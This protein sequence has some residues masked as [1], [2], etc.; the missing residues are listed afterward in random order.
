MV[1]YLCY[2]QDLV[3]FL[4]QIFEILYSI[5]SFLTQCRMKSTVF[6]AERILSS[7]KF[8]KM[9]DHLRGQKGYKIG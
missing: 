5:C 4:K 9:H 3:D 8:C 1:S 6:G 2:Q 7:L